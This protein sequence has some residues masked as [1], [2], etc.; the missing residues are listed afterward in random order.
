MESPI[1]LNFS[2]M[3]ETIVLKT[4]KLTLNFHRHIL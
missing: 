4:K 3:R 1:E 2:N